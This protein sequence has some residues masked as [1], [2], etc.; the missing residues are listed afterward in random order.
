[1][2]DF[3]MNPDPKISYNKQVSQI[4]KKDFWHLNE[5]VLVLI[6]MEDGVEY[7]F[8]LPK[9]FLTDGASVPRIAWSIVPMWD[10][11]TQAVLVHDYLCEENPVYS[12]MEG[13]KVLNRKEVDKIFLYA[14]EAC[15][16]SK[17]KRET[18]YRAVRLATINGTSNFIKQRRAVKKH[19][20]KLIAEN[21]DGG[22]YNG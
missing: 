14:M 20:S 7:Q 2:I 3:S 11:C 8:T 6:T 10:E 13:W 19:Y 1:M 22:Y 16:V 21:I 5:D 4:L 18:I 17:L 12:P 15:G 9:G